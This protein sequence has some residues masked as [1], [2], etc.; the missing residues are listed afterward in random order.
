MSFDLVELRE[1]KD[2]EGKQNIL[3]G[4]L[5]GREDTGGMEGVFMVLD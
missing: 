1:R 5:R 3:L 2:R 4:G